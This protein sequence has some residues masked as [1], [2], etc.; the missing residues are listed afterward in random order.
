MRISRKQILAGG[1]VLLVIVVAIVIAIVCFSRNDEEKTEY[2]DVTVSKVDMKQT[3][4][5]AG[6]ITAGKSET[7]NVDRNRTFKGAAVETD[8]QVD[9]GQALVYYTD[10]THTD[11]PADCIVTG[12]SLPER[13]ERADESHCIRLKRTGD[14]YMKIT[15][16]QEEI[17]KIN[18]GSEAV[19]IVN[20]LSQQ[21]FPGSIVE[22]KD[23]P[24]SFFESE[25]E[26]QTEESPEEGEDDGD[27][28]EDMD[29]ELGESDS[30]EGEGEEGSARYTITLKFRNNGKVRPGMSAGCVITISD[31]SGITA[32]PIQAV[33]F[34]ENDRAY[35]EKVSGRKT[36]RVFVETGESDAMNVEIK[37]G[38][39]VGDK[40]RMTVHRGEGD[41]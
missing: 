16:P 18:S 28:E 11:A 33:S 2:R 37:S 13:G 23:V 34:D 22:K 8:E 31:R 6:K 41:K 27:T 12:M 9:E 38:L 10:G 20:A 4:T 3:L 29:E 5:A 24:N 35:V 30:D 25:G 19:I 21:N 15:V 36:E 7:V 40:V 26:E 14:M 1:A 17:N 32:V 39:E